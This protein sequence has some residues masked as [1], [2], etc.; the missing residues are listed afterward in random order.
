METFIK[1]GDLVESLKREK[2]LHYKLGREERLGYEQGERP[3][4]WHYEATCNAYANGIDYTIRQIQYYFSEELKQY[5]EID[6]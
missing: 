1:I 2:E 4:G 5:D 6:Y 3:N